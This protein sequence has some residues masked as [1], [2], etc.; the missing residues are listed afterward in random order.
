[1]TPAAPAAPLSYRSKHELQLGD[2]VVVPLRNAKVHGVVIG[3]TKVEDAKSFLK[4]ADF[5]LAKSV[6]RLDGRLPAPLMKAAQAIA[7]WHAVPLGSALHALLSDSLALDLPRLMRE[8]SGFVLRRFE[9]PR[10]TRSEKYRLLIDK[11][12]EEKTS[13]LL[14]VPTIAELREFRDAFAAYEPIILS[15]DVKPLDR[16]AR[17]QEAAELPRLIIATPAYAFMGIER[18]GICIVERPSAASYTM[19]K[20]PYLNRVKALELLAQERSV[21]LALGD[22]PLPLEYREVLERPLSQ[23]PRSIMDVVDLKSVRVEGETWRALPEVLTKRIEAALKGGGRIA[24]LAARKGYAPAVVCRDCGTALTDDKNLPLS[25]ATVGEKRM[26]RRTDGSFLTSADA[27][28]PVC[29]SWNLIGLGVGSERVE[30][31]LREQFPSADIARFDADTVKT[32]PQAKKTVEVLRTPGKHGAILVGTEAMLPWLTAG[33]PKKGM[34]DLAVIASMDSLLALPFWRSRER[35]VRMGLWLRE[36]SYAGVLGTH[37]TKDSAVAAVT[38]DAGAAFFL[39]ERDLRRALAYP[40]FGTLLVVTVTAGKTKV[41]TEA[42]RI[43]A[44]L[45]EYHPLR[46]SPRL[47]KESQAMVPLVIR[48]PEGA[49]PNETLS[50]RLA[51]LPPSVRVRIDPESFY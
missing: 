41:A 8:G 25:L 2:V 26:L 31:E 1:M 16:A 32:D 15:G 29:G 38:S 4:T 51:A 9:F 27:L 39:E 22:Y 13:V 21:P 46:L 36:R 6:V 43:E 30:A 47:V 24:V 42:A 35:F 19:L 33:L 40:P 7:A 17:L 11:A 12:L 3:V 48:L 20:R 44:L 23:V 28:C 37:R 34:L 18:L 14:L 10:E 5:A 50:K 49:W 45:A